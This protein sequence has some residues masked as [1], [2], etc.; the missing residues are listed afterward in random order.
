MTMMM[1]VR[2]HSHGDSDDG[3][4]NIDEMEAGM[5]SREAVER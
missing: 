2:V 3:E 4:N 5:T 1:V